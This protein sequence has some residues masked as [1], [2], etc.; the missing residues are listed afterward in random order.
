MSERLARYE[1][2]LMQSGLFPD[3]PNKNPT[4]FEGGEN[5]I[6]REGSVQPVPGQFLIFTLGTGNP[7][8]GLY[9]QIVDA[10]PLLTVGTVGALY[11]WT[12]DGGVV[13]DKTGFSG[14]FR[15]TSTNPA[16]RWSMCPWGN[17]T[18]ATNGRDK[19][20]VYKTTGFEDMATAAP[21]T[22]E[23]V[24]NRSPFL[25][26]F[27][28]DEGY[29]YIEWCD[30]DD[31]ETWAASASNWAGNLP[32]RDLPGPINCA[33][34]YRG[35]TAFFTEETMHMLN[36]LGAGNVFGQRKLLEGIGTVGK[37]AAV[38]A[39]GMV[40]GF[41]PR[42]IWRTDG[43]QYSYIDPD[44]VR[45]FVYKDIAYEQR[46]QVVAW[47]DVSLG[48]VAF[49]YP[50]NGRQANSNCVAFD[51]RHNV[52]TVYGMRRTAVDVGQ[53]LRYEV[54]GTYQG[55]VLYQSV[56]GQPPTLPVGNLAV[57]DSGTIKAGYGEA[58][59]GQLGYGGSLDVEG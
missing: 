38:Q 23:I 9:S 8:T 36:F 32:V 40:Y 49:F 6:F 33:L 19:P 57:N 54:T 58:G 1:K 28:T 31:I 14:S 46:S 20:Q 42:G 59:Y 21:D 56:S 26:F 52:W 51:Y 48:T 45:S 12:A 15:A 53:A 44:V 10:E 47:H 29:E 39:Q 34:N 55:E 27:N 7:P 18:I 24:V 2:D 16:T 13:E 4:F 50:E 22:A 11:R 35:E 30:R 37:H 43:S 5:I 25:V 41:G 3:L 17:W